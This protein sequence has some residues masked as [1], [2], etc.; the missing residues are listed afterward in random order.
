TN[1]IIAVNPDPERGQLSSLQTGLKEVRGAFA[2]TTV[3]CPAVEESTVIA[4]ARAFEAR[5]PGA[6]FVV[7]QYRGKHG[8][9]VFA[10]HAVADEMLA[11]PATAQARDVVHRH[12]DRTQ[13]I[14]VDDPGILTDIDDREAHRRLTEAVR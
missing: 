10:A 12:V 13:Y 4:A 7:P 11:L 1:A 2:F 14:D 6:L 3:D 5:D 8:H 9:P